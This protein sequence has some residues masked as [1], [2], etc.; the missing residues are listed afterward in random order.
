MIIFEGEWKFSSI[1]VVGFVLKRVLVLYYFTCY[2]YMY[3]YI[4]FKLNILLMLCLSLR[5]ELYN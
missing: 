1:R 5:N 4:F 3:V 2:K